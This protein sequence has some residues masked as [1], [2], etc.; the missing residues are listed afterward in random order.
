MNPQ[1]CIYGY[2]G[3]WLEVYLGE[4]SG[5][6]YCSFLGLFVEVLLGE[7]LLIRDWKMWVVCFKLLPTAKGDL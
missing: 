7:L 1:V 6:T 3:I 2:L 5:S 4:I